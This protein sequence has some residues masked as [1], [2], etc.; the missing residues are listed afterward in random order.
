VPDEDAATWQVADSQ[1]VRFPPGNPLAG[2]GA[3]AEPGRARSLI[4]DSPVTSATPGSDVHRAVRR[5]RA[6]LRE[7][8]L[9][10]VIAAVL[11]VVLVAGA[12]V[13]WPYMQRYTGAAPPAQFYQEVQVEPTL[14][15]DYPRVLGVAHNAG[16]NLGTLTTAMH[17]GAD[18]IEIDVISARGQ[19]VGRS[20]PAVVLAGPAAVPGADAG[21]SLGSGGC[22]RHRQARP[23]ADGSQVPE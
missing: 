13:A 23:E 3:T 20:R 14:T 9:R 19:L 1:P 22:C 17:Y 16:N 4:G 8:R 2:F 21:G 15:Q 5:G 7:G 10:W 12:I 11:V 6:W 18:V